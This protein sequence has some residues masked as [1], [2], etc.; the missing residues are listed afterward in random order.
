MP[1][2][3]FL[4]LAPVICSMVTASAAVTGGSI[5]FHLPIRDQKKQGTF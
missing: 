2:P 5:A 4:A 3:L 1:A